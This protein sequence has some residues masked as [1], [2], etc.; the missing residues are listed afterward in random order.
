MSSKQF[1]TKDKSKSYREGDTNNSGSNNDVK[2]YKKKKSY[3]KGESY[4]KR[5]PSDTR[6]E[7][8]RSGID[9]ATKYS[10]IPGHSVSEYVGSQNDPAWYNRNTRLIQDAAKIPFSNQLGALVDMGETLQTKVPGTNYV[11]SFSVPGVM[12]LK[13]MNVPGIATT[14]SDGPNLAAA[15]LFQFIRKNLSTVATYAAADVMMYVLGLDSIYSQYANIARVF[16][17]VNA[18]SS[19]NLYMPDALLRAGYGFSAGEWG[20]IRM[21]LNNYRSRF[22]NLIYKASSLYLPTDFTIT[23]RHAWLYSNYFMDGASAKAQLYIHRM[24]G[25]HQLNETRDRKSVV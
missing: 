17:I 9:K 14:A 22:N 13:M 21:N 12:A 15:G 23:S 4:G 7:R 16:G 19:I 20:I 6:N 11:S 25:Y 2:Q 10:E 3:R 8:T 18:Y 1:D 24:M 5:P